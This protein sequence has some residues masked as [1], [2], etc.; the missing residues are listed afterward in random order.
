ME[1]LKCR[2]VM[3]PTDNKSH[4]SK[5][6]DVI[7]Y[8]IKPLSKVTETYTPQHLYF[9]SDEKIQVGDFYIYPELSGNN[10]WTNKETILDK[11]DYPGAMKVIA[12]T[13]ESLKLP[14]IPDSFI[15]EYVEANG[16]IDAVIIETKLVPIQQLEDYGFV[17]RPKKTWTRD[18]VVQL[19]NKNA[20]HLEKLF[21]KP[22]N[23][24][25]GAILQFTQYWIAE[26]LKSPKGHINF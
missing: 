15:E 6:K 8:H 23:R 7:L 2:V 24:C 18:E 3:L 10:V 26:N 21:K 13:D 17:S 16:K 5:G 4:I 19:L 20:E 11:Q 22:E 25:S 14:L 1:K 9:L 12:S